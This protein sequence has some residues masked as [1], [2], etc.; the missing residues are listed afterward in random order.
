[1]AKYL[2]WQRQIQ[3]HQEDR[4]VNGMETDDILS[5]QMQICRPV[6][7]EHL[8]AVAITVIAKSGDIVRQRIQPYIGDMIRIEG[9]RN[10]PVEGGSGYTQI[11]K[12]WKQEVVHHLVLS[13]NRLNELWMIVDVLD[14]AVSVFAHFE[15][16][17]LFLGWLNLTAAVRAFA[18]H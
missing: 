13:G 2:L 5:D 16:I 14:Q 15:E 17:C 3:S 9:D 7:L 12:S 8:T 6:F 10:S 4:P 11:L 1:M 18:V